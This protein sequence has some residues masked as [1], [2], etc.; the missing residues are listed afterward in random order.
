MVTVH[1]LVWLQ[2]LLLWLNV[3][4]TIR[5]VLKV[6]AA[7]NQGQPVFEDGVYYTKAPSMLLIFNILIKLKNK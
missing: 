6:D 2:Y 7:T 5:Y 4:A 1:V 3:I